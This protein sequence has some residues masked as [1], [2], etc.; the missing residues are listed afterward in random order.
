MT[1]TLVVT[2]K[3]G[4]NQSHAKRHEDDGGVKVGTLKHWTR[5]GWRVCETREPINL[6]STVRRI[7]LRRC[8]PCV[9]NRYTSSLSRNK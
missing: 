2:C 1:I 5:H 6:L 7:A 3:R 8:A 9:A 4:G